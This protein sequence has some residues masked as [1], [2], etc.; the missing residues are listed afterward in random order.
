MW[1]HSQGTARVVGALTINC[2]SPAGQRHL[3]LPDTHETGLH[4]MAAHKS[5][6]QE[7]PHGP[8]FMLQNSCPVSETMVLGGLVAL[9]TL[10]LS[11]LGLSVSLTG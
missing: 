2:P 6:W 4:H 5:P 10:Q 9:F 8:S 3:S 7:E 1:I 11:G